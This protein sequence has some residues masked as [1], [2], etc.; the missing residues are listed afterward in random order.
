MA[1]NP[2]KRGQDKSTGA[3]CAVSVC[4]HIESIGATRL[5]V[6]PKRRQVGRQ[7]PITHDAESRRVAPHG[8]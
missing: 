1:Q 6:A 5:R 4:L 3:K 7:P 2:K 8:R